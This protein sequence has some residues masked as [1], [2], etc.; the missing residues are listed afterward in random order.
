MRPSPKA[1]QQL[2]RRQ[3]TAAFPIF[4]EIEH[5][6]FPNGILRIVNFHTSLT[7]NGNVYA[8]AGFEFTPPKQGD[9]TVGNA[10]VVISA[11][12]QT[13]IQKIREM[14]S[15]AKATTVASFYI[16]EGGSV[17]IEPM[18]EWT[19]TLGKVSWNEISAT[20]EMIFDERMD[21]VVP[22]HR[23]NQVNCAGA[24]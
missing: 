8:A 7:F 4:L 22:V 15:R 6:I 3:T 24:S 19:F 20:W 2:F 17:I 11:I 14:N 12:D 9:K 18:E 13:V 10:Q 21:R 5:A 1:I 16:D 23:M